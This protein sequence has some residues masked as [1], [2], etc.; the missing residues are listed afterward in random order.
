VPPHRPGIADFLKRQAGLGNA[1]ISRG[2]SHNPRLIGHGSNCS[3]SMSNER[4]AMKPGIGHGVKQKL[5]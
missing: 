5:V 2:L 4:E 1:R 3:S